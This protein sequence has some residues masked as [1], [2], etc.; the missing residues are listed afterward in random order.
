MSRYLTVVT[1]WRAYGGRSCYPAYNPMSR[2]LTVVTPGQKDEGV[3]HLP[4]QIS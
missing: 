3:F 1:R 4:A 2:Y